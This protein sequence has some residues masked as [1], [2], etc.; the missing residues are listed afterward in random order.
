MSKIY[1]SSWFLSFK[2]FSASKTIKSA[3]NCHGIKNPTETNYSKKELSSQMLN[4]NNP[5]ST[6]CILNKQ[7]H[8]NNNF[9]HIYQLIENWWLHSTPLISHNDDDSGNGGHWSWSKQ[10]FCTERELILGYFIECEKCKIR[11]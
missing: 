3:K 6:I 4:L 7:M 5:Y 8:K 2:L 1:F 10:R 9:F 11:V